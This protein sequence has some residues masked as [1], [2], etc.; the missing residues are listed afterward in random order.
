MDLD[1]NLQ[2]MVGIIHEE[3]INQFLGMAYFGGVFSEGKVSVKAMSYSSEEP[4]PMR[5]IVD[6]VGLWRLRGFSRFSV[7]HL[8]LVCITPW[9]GH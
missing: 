9:I 1:K 6:V 8:I 5:A 4:Y 3:S 2:T 7:V